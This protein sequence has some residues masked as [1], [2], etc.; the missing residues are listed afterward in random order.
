ML[1]DKRFGRYEILRKLGRSMTDVYLA[2][3]EEAGRTVALKIIEESHDPATQLALSAERRGVLIQKQLREVDSRILEVYDFGEESGCFFVAMEYVEGRN[4]AEIIQAEKRLDPARAVRYAREVLNQLGRLHSFLTEIDGRKRAVVHGDIKPSNIQIDT[5]DQVRLLDFGIAKVITFTHNLTHHNLGSPSYCSPER[6]LK[7]QVDPNVDLW[8]AGVTLYEMIAGAPPYQAQTTR[9]L[10]NLIQSRRPP[11]SLPADCPP[12]LAAIISRALAADIGRRY[13]NAAAFESDLAAFLAGRPTA[14]ELNTAPPWDS[15]QTIEKS[16]E[17]Q[18]VRKISLPTSGF[19]REFKFVFS[20]LAAG[21]L[22]GLFVLVPALRAARFW[23]ESR[24]LRHV[25]S[26]SG[27]SAADIAADWALYKKLER[28]NSIVSPVS[29]VRQP[30][31]ASLIAAGDEVIERYANSSDPSAAD[32]DWRKAQTCLARALDLDAS[33]SAVKGKL[34]LVS[35]YLVL[36][37]DSPDAREAKAGFEEAAA[38]AP[39]SADPHLGL[40]RVYVYLLHNVGSAVAEFHQAERLGFKIGPREMAQQADGYLARAQ[41]ELLQA[42]GASKTSPAEEARLLALARRDFDRANNLYEP[43]DGFSNV[44]L[45]LQNL[46][47]GRSREEQLQQTYEMAR[48]KRPRSRRW[49]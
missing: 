18:R 3:D 9:K 38:L 13:P 32:F 29:K 14:A 21:F 16:P 5:N 33:D 31:R 4:I 23:S 40:A 42:E 24:S 45:H 43:I 15:N 41:S 48:V 47:K 1:H 26:Y 2:L 35:A 27:K 37:Q 28:D 49:R 17:V 34:A 8:A 20:T 6:L 7:G 10:E 25:R 30:F 46:Y 39:R 36:A 11:R 44:S 12:A 19:L 22:I